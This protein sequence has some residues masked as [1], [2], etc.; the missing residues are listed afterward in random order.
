MKLAAAML[1]KRFCIFSEELDFSDDDLIEYYENN[2]I[3]FDYNSN[4]YLIK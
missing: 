4:S 1:I 2:K 3:I